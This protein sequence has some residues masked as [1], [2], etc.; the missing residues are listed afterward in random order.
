MNH[1]DGSGNEWINKG[2]NILTA[3]EEFNLLKIIEDEIA[4]FN[5]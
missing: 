2:K 4:R 1:R 5:K 3:I